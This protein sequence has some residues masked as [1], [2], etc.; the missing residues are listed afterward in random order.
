SI[1]G[2]AAVAATSRKISMDSD[3]SCENIPMDITCSPKLEQFFYGSRFGID[4][5]GI[6]IENENRAG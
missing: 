4:I 5:S 2:L 6:I 3:S 1:T